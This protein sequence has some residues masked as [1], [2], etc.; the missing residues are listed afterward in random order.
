[1]ADPRRRKTGAAAAGLEQVRALAHPLR[2]KLLELFAEEPLT[3]KQAAQKLG[4]PPTRLYHHVAT[5]ERAGILR[6]KE[7]RAVR[8][9]TE[10]YFEIA[11]IPRLSRRQAA[12]ALRKSTVQDRE[13]IGFALFDQARNEL[14]QALGARQAGGTDPI[15][16]IRTV[17]WLSPAAARR[18]RRELMQVLGRLR[19]EQKPEGSKHRR[20]N[21]KRYALTISMVPTA[22]T[23]RR[24]ETTRRARTDSGASA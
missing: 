19:R 9:A 3:A 15:M 21:A 7:T 24:V 10:K 22:E 5:L 20:R 6:L 8:G 4:Q 14:L 16:A 2:L 11:Q 18:L 23:A 12:A 17:A 13:A 1:M